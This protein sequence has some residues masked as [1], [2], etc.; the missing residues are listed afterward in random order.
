MK[1]IINYNSVGKPVSYGTVSS[2]VKDL[3]VVA[4]TYR[5]PMEVTVGS[6]MVIEEVRALIFEGYC[7][8]KR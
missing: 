6:T 2:Y 3:A 1:L 4:E 5:E 8:M 7:L